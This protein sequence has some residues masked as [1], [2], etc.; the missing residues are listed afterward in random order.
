MAAPKTIIDLVETFK[1]NEHIYTNGDLFDEE[2]DDYD[3]FDDF[4]DDEE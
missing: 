3:D 4:D 1:K 2:E